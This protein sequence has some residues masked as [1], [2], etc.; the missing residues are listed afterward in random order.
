MEPYDAGN[1]FMVRQLG[2]RT[3]SSKV[4]KQKRNKQKGIL[5]TQSPME[6]GCR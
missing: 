6:H 1:L 3:K 2:K 4:I 5:G